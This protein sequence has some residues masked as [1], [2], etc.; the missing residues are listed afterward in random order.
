MGTLFTHHFQ[1]GHTSQTWGNTLSSF[2]EVWLEV[3]S[4][5]TQNLRK[6]MKSSLIVLFIAM[7]D[8]HN[9]AI[10]AILKICDYRNRD[11]LKCHNRPIT[12]IPLLAVG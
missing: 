3:K 6:N 9:I 1:A 5:M 4:L 2:L 7:N 12:T 11:Y 10:I 8:Y